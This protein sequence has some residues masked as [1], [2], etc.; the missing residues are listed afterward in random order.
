[1]YFSKLKMDKYTKL[2]IFKM[3]RL[4]SICKKIGCNQL[5]DSPGYCNDHKQIEQQNKREA[6]KVIK[7]RQSPE[8]KAFYNSNLWHRASRR[9][10]KKEPLCRRCKKY[11]RVVIGVLVHHNPPLEVLQERG[12]NPYLDDYLETLCFPCHNKEL[13]RKK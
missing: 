13:R 11:G 3:K 8:Q 9:H 12:F 5:I 10:R 1:M 6:W 7:D 4:K 2:K